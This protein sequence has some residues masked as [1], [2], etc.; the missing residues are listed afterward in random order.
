MSTESSNIPPNL[1]RILNRFAMLI[2]SPKATKWEGVSEEEISTLLADCM[3]ASKTDIEIAN[4]L[5]SKIANRLEELESKLKYKFGT[6]FKKATEPWRRISIEHLKKDTGAP[7]TDAFP[8]EEVKNAVKQRLQKWFTA[9]QGTIA[10]GIKSKDLLTLPELQEA[11]NAEKKDIR[12]AIRASRMFFVIG[13]DH[14]KYYPAFFADSSLYFRKCLE[15]VCKKLTAVPAEVKYGF[16]TTSIH[17]LGDQTP[18]E[19]LNAGKLR[20]IME[21]AGDIL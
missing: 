5:F 16:F 1:R 17:C 7:L 21:I 19:A 15:K 2:A 8:T 3:N 11:M 20:E 14:Q 10:S 13:P 12:N 6:E 18:V 9:N 4:A